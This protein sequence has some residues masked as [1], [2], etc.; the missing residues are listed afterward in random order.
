METLISRRGQT[1]VPA[2]IRLRYKIKDGDKL[3]WIDDGL[4]IRVIPVPADPIK[5]LRG[6]GKGQKLT[7]KLLTERRKERQREN[8][9]AK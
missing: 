4:V 1:V 3:I 7:A 9:H 5:A 8:R 2:T 6:S